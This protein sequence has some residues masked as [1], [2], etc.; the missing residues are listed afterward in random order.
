MTRSKRLELKQALLVTLLN[1][2]LML[3][4]CFFVKFVEYLRKMQILE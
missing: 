3:A 4:T 2:L 1:A